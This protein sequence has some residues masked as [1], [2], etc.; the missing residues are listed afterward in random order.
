MTV[1][2]IHIVGPEQAGQ[3]ERES[4][5]DAGPFVHHRDEGARISNFVGQTALLLET[6]EG[7]PESRPVDPVDEAHHD[8]L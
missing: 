7:R 8:S 2:H 1:N 5:G 4:E 3:S 6:T